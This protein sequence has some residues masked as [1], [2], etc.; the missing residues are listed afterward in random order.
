[1]DF[2]SNLVKIKTK[3]Q[4][5][6]T[7]EDFNK[8]LLDFEKIP[9]LQ[10]P[11]HYFLLFIM[12]PSL[13]CVA[14][15][16]AMPTKHGLTINMGVCDS[17]HR[18]VSIVCKLVSILSRSI[19]EKMQKLFTGQTKRSVMYRCPQSDQIPLQWIQLLD[20]K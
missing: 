13:F 8:L 10:I 15:E 2:F 5:I 14:T 17:G 20:T 12:I 3:V 7:L 1:M 9:N 16:V 11:C 19:L 6:S 4:T 18:K